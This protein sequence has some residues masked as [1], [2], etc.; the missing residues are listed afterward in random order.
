V[1]GWNIREL[2]KAIKATISASYNH[3]HADVEVKFTT[4]ASKIHIR[5][6]NELSRM[7]SNQ[8]LECLSIILCI[9]P[10][11][12]LFK[13]LDEDG[14]GSWA[15]CGGAYKLNSSENGR[16]LRAV[17]SKISFAS[18]E[19]GPSNTTSGAFILIS[20]TNLSC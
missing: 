16:S 11:I 6:D 19:D 7:M 12:W 18:T 8:W 4:S 15:V 9:F 10:F 2:E 5:P 1:Y 20:G 13:Q 3:I 17:Q 14:G